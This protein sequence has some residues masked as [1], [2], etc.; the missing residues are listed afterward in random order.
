MTEFGNRKTG[1]VRGE[2]TGNSPGL[3][4]VLPHLPAAAAG[5]GLTLVLV[6]GAL[7][8]SRPRQQRSAAAPIPSPSAPAAARRPVPRPAPAR[9]APAS[10]EPEVQVR[11]L[12][13]AHP[14]VASRP[15]GANAPSS[16]PPLS[17]SL[18]P[19]EN[20][21]PQFP[22]E[23]IPPQI[24]ELPSD[25]GSAAVESPP[26]PDPRAG[27]EAPPIQR[28]PVR[29]A[30]PL[31]PSGSLSIYFDAD[32]STFGRHGRRLPLRVEVWVDGARRLA[33]EDPEKEEFDL[34]R[35]PEGEH[36]I[37]IVPFVGNSPAEPREESVFIA[38]REPNRY[39]AV[40]RKEDGASRISKF[41]PRD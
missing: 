13:G 27:T 34:G 30:R 32:S 37:R 31:R 33:S 17:G 20:A 19:V 8:L 39:K 3:R 12:P 10:D 14:N 28:P 41:K 5:A 26:A 38:P 35:L 24:P 2:A 6:L 23:A 15:P 21:P 16:L 22:G 11:T 40:L 1:R 4:A 36:R 29:R 25:A 18:P 9:Q 7:A